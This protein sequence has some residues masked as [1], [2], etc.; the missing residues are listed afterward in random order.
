MCNVGIV[1]GEASKKYSFPD[2]PLGIERVEA[3]WQIL[4]TERITKKRGIKI[5]EPVLASEEVLLLF[6]TKGHV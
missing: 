4:E 3:F 1:L 2:H 6:H 5:V